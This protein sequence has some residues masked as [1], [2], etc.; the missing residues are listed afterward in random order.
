MLVAPVQTT[1]LSFHIEWQ[2]ITGL[3]YTA[4]N[5]LNELSMYSLCCSMFGRTADGFKLLQI[6]CLFLIL[7]LF[8]VG[9][10]VVCVLVSYLWFPMAKVL[11]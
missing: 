11:C 6:A 10:E 3:Y 8:V 9:D 1:V 7:H 4:S 2:V 5:K